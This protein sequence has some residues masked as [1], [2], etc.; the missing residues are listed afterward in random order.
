MTASFKTRVGRGL[1]TAAVISAG[2]TAGMS[3]L[4]GASVAHAQ[5]PVVSQTA[6]GS[7][8]QLSHLHSSIP[9]NGQQLRFI[10]KRGG[11][12]SIQ[13][14]GTNQDNIRAARCVDTSGSNKGAKT[15]VN[16]WWWVGRTDVT[17]WASPGCNANYIGKV[18]FDAGSAPAHWTDWRC[19]EDVD[20]FNEYDC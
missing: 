17:L 2:I 14:T 3:P 13:I 4:A 18:F 16:N 5:D 15:D 12:K 11:V 20:P 8:T 6:S 7:L 10:D 9:S 19:V 1:L